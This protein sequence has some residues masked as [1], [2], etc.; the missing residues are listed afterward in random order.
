MNNKTWVLGLALIVLSALV[1]LAAGLDDIRLGP[2][3]PLGLGPASARGM[4][5]PSL[6][7]IDADTPVWKILLFWFAFVVNLAMFL[8]VLPPELRKRMLRQLTSFA[9]GV[10]ALML[11]LRYRLLELPEMP[12][13]A[14][15]HGYASSTGATAD[16]QAPQPPQVA[17]WIAYVVSLI[18][19][20]VILLVLYFA[21]RYW[22]HHRSQR[23]AALGSIGEIARKSLADLAGGHQWGDVVT[24]AYAR[25]N[26]AVRVTRGLQRESSSTPREFAARLVRTGLPISSVD[27][28][29]RLFEAV[30][31]GGRLSD[32]AAALRAAACL[33]SILQACGV[34]A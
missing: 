9:I 21:Y 20:W 32:D 22:N 30:R 14:A 33:E 11:A 25:M 12:V 24:Q 15:E 4:V 6:K 5:L 29:T 13:D 17:P 3:R 7:V 8:L 23:S 16:L 26:E 1:L 10:L 19:L 28:L 27:E 31:Y 34:A 2:G 18:V